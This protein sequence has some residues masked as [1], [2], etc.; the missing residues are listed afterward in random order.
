MF[1]GAVGP[2]DTGQDE[3][4]TVLS[5]SS[6]RVQASPARTRGEAKAAVKTRSC[7]LVCKSFPNR[8][9]ATE[10][11]L[12]TQNGGAGRGCFGGAVALQEGGDALL[13]FAA[14]RT[15]FLL[16]CFCRRA[17]AEPA[18]VRCVQGRRR[19]VKR[20]RFHSVFV[21][22]SDSGVPL[23]DPLKGN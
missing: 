22:V 20:S 16:R 10:N 15:F 17:R 14:K 8:S 4:S 6:F 3:R 2:A 9:T 1:G 12:R 13:V 23:C 7:L 11:G 19:L 21:L 5:K 18:F